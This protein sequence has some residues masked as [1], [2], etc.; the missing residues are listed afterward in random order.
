MSTESES[1][2]EPIDFMRREQDDRIKRE[3]KELYESY[4]NPW[5]LL[6]ELA[7]N[8]VDAIKEWNEEYQ[9]SGDDRDHEIRLTINKDENAVSIE[10]TGIGIR[11][12]K[13]P[14]LLA[15]HGTDKSGDTLTIGEKGVGLTFCIFSSNYFEIDTISEDGHFKGYISGARDWWQGGEVEPPMANPEEEDEDSRSPDETR[16]KVS[17]ED[18]ELTDYRDGQTLFDLNIERIVHLIRTKTALGY[19]RAAL[20]GEENDEDPDISV[21]VTVIED[22]EPVLDEEEIKFRYRFPHE[23][24]EDGETVDINEIRSDLPLDDDHKTARLRSKNLKIT[25]SEQRS[26]DRVV[27]YYAF[28]MPGADWEK[29]SKQND[30]VGEDDDVH[31]LEAGIYIATRGMPTSVK[32]TPPKTGSSGYWRGIYMILEYD[33]IP[34]DL[35]RKSLTGRKSMLQDVAK[36]VF[37]QELLPFIPYIRKAPPTSPTDLFRER[38]N[39][40]D[41]LEQMTDLDCDQISFRKQP[42]N[43]VAGVVSIFHEL[44]GSGE[45]EY[46]QGLR[47]GYRQDYDFWGKYSITENELGDNIDINDFHDDVV[48]MNT[49]TGTRSV[50]EEIVIEFKHDGADILTEFEGK[51]KELDSIDIVVCWELSESSM[52]NVSVSELD[53]DEAKYAGCNYEIVLPNNAVIQNQTKYVMELSSLIESL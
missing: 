12:D 29:V 36:N 11:P 2:P 49:A 16:T 43:D 1:A 52:T 25:G 18:L 53:S 21:F 26:Q 31:D 32:L 5:D 13:L 7:Q 48:T 23:F 15:P 41:D 3:I 47:S 42:D 14:G 28:Y 46:Y 9:D 51:E 34:F 35:G 37:N 45:L 19:I 22:S 6:A 30:L 20:R 10:D 8:S 33:K 38:F 39:R 44:V 50:E 17:L 4:D 27:R 40:F 24:F